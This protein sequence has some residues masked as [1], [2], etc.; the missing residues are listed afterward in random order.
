M[1]NVKYIYLQIDGESVKHRTCNQCGKLFP[2]FIQNKRESGNC[3][4]CSAKIARGYRKNSYAKMS[5]ETKAKNRKLGEM[6]RKRRCATD[7]KYSDRLKSYNRMHHRHVRHGRKIKYCAECN[8]YKLL[9]AF[10]ECNTTSD[11][12]AESCTAC[13][14]APEL[15]KLK[16]ELARLGKKKS[17]I[18][19]VYLGKKGNIP[20]V[21]GESSFAYFEGKK[22]TVLSSDKNKYLVAREVCDAVGVEWATAKKYRSTTCEIAS[23]QYGGMTA[24]PIPRLRI[25]R[26]IYDVVGLIGA[27]RICKFANEATASAFR[28]WALDTLDVLRENRVE[29]ECIPPTLIE[30]LIKR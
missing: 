16:N 23:R 28:S 20:N 7:K 5:A 4:K 12:Y 1:R 17:N 22:M 3:R 14:K 10:S 15:K 27:V 6:R 26:I 18:Q 9:T 8:R 11:G 21:P 29:E 19:K 13:A 2:V 30:K 25:D 24:I